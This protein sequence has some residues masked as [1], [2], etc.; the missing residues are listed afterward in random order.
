M[1][2]TFGRAHDNSIVINKPD[3]SSHHAKV[4]FLGNGNFLVEDLSSANGVFINGHRIQKAH[5]GYRDELRLSE[6]TPLNLVALF[7]LNA[8]RPPAQSDKTGSRDFVYEFRELKQIWE[9]Y[10]RIRLEINNRYQRKSTIVR[11]LLSLAPLAV[12]II[13]QYTYLNQFEKT[14]PRYG[15]WQG[16]FIYFSVIGG[17]IGNLVGGLMIPSPQAKLSLLDEEFRVRYVCPNPECR[18]QLGGVPWLSYHNQGKCF[19]CQA[20]YSDY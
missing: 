19:R 2:K 20:K 1:V 14:D 6:S 11:S 4:T 12:W 5:I 13:F 10:Q 9:D 7:E 8:P 16:S 18:T 3:I 17:A 15:E